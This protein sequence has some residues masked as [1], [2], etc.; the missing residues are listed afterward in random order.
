MR[1]LGACLLIVFFGLQYKL[2][3]G[4][5]SVYELKKIKK[6]TVKQASMNAELINY[7]NAL[8]S[9]IKTLK[10]GTD[11]LEAQARYE[12]GMVKEASLSFNLLSQ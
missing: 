4:D 6:E 1:G 8:F 5:G 2:W 9:D 10:Q 3:F 11:A 12:F 7:N